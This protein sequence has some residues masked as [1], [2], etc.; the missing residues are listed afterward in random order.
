ML[1]LQSISD[2][3]EGWTNSSSLCAPLVAVMWQALCTVLQLSSSD[4]NHPDCFLNHICI[5]E[6]NWEV[7]ALCRM[8]KATAF[9]MD[10]KRV[11]Q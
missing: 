5:I 10:R 3:D 6:V 2:V 7:Q 4:S 1:L 8:P 11:L 9:K